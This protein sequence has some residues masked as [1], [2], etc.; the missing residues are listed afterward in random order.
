MEIKG[1]LARSEG[2][3]AEGKLQI[4]L[5]NGALRSFGLKEIKML[6]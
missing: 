6:L 3:S 4:T 5:A 1:C 2:V